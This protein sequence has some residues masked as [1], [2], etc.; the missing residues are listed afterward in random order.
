MRLPEQERCSLGIGPRIS[1]QR[2]TSGGCRLPSLFSFCEKWKIILQDVEEKMFAPMMFTD[3]NRS[4]GGKWHDADSLLK[5]FPIRNC[6][7]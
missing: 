7:N 3:K 6:K 2:I 5:G 4:Y 1:L